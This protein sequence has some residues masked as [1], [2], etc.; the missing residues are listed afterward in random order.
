MMTPSGFMTLAMTHQVVNF[1]YVFLNEV[2]VIRLVKQ[3]G[4][5]C[6]AM[7]SPSNPSIVSVAGEFGTQL[8]DIRHDPCR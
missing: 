8:I 7:F 5:L 6:S 2:P 3:P 1:I 4:R